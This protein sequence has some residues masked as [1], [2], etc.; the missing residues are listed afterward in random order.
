MYSPH[1]L[2]FALFTVGTL[3]YRL[4]ANLAKLY[5]YHKALNPLSFP[6]P[7]IYEQESNKAC[8]FSTTTSG[9]IRTAASWSVNR[10]LHWRISAFLTKIWIVII[11][12]VERILCILRS[13]TESTGSIL[14]Q[15]PVGLG[16]IRTVRVSLRIVSRRW[17]IGLWRHFQVFR[18]E[19]WKEMGQD[20]CGFY[21]RSGQVWY[22][23]LH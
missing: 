21:G 20:R 14:F 16:G 19:L 13:R 9:A 11:N 8:L 15:V 10:P 1:L 7:N 4:P 12:I 23:R 2:A 3:S 5:N 22:M 6:A 18:G 17:G